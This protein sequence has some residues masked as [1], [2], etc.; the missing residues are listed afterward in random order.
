MNIMSS[1]ISVDTYDYLLPENKIALY[2]A[3]SRDQSKL[4]CYDGSRI[5]DTEVSLLPEILDKG[6][7]M[8]F[9]N[10]RVIRA[11]L[12][13]RKSTGAFIEV[14]CLEPLLP[15]PELQT[16]MQQKETTTWKCLVG[17]VSRWKSGEL[18]TII[19][20]NDRDLHLNAEITSKLN[21]SFQ[22]CFHWT[23]STFTFSEVLEAA[24]KIPLP[25]YIKRDAELLDAE[26]YQTVYSKSE[27]SVAAPTAG[28]HFTPELFRKI[29]KKGIDICELTLHVG[30]G[31]FRPLIS[32]N[33]ND[34]IM[35]QE[36]VSVDF[37]LIEKLYNAR[38]K[39][40]AVGTTSVRT[41]ESLYYLGLQVI[42]KGG[43]ENVIGQWEPYVKKTKINGKQALE[44]L[45]NYMIKADT[46]KLS[47]HTRILIMPSYKFRITDGIFT[48]FH[49]PR[50]T[51]L[52]LIAAYL[53]DD[54]KKIYHHAL[55][56]HYRFLSYGDACLFLK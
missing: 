21:D 38:E 29:K 50:S 40:I 1:S 51:L 9:N 56:N 4:L 34:H 52:L 46:D 48:N 13:F 36:Q 20:H 31:T 8:V 11:R 45:L 19:Q 27:G 25:P 2:P 24:G 44:A 49:Q 3:R 30:A 33:I 53:G 22:V 28:L 23:P 18:Q 43:H 55:N 26:R 6:M 47:F 42:E 54:W 32:G 15:S 35:H 41:L 10:S 5:I 12:I 37:K 7:L 16:A 17:N 14:F 39:I